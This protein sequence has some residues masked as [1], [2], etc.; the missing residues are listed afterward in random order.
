MDTLLTNI[1][2]NLINVILLMALTNFTA[3]Q[4]NIEYNFSSPCQNDSFSSFKN[5]TLSKEY[6]KT[7]YRTCKKKNAISLMVKCNYSEKLNF[8]QAQTCNVHLCHHLAMGENH[9]EPHPLKTEN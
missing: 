8:L 1:D 9:F 5:I 7:R 3:M 6:N 4:S 2:G